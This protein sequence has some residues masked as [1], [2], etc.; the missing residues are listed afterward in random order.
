[1]GHQVILFWDACRPA[2]CNAV[3]LDGAFAIANHFKQMGTNRVETIVTGKPIV[4]I[5][6]S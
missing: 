5:E 3:V 4:G 2:G 6:R 1:L